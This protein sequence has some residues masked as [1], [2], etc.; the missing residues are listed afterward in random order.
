MAGMALAVWAAGYEGTSGTLMVR[1]QDLGKRHTGGGL[2]L[3]Q[4]AGW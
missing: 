2:R 3:A 4:E 1:K